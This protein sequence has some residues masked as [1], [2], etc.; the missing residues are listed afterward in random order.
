MDRQSAG[1]AGFAALGAGRAWASRA[2]F[3]LRNEPRRIEVIVGELEIDVGD[4]ACDR[5]RRCSACCG[6]RLGLGKVAFSGVGER[7]RT[8]RGGATCFGETAP[9][10]VGRRPLPRRIS[11]PDTAPAPSDSRGSRPGRLPS[12]L[13]RRSPPPPRRIG[14]PASARGFRRRP[15][16]RRSPSR[17]VQ[18]VCHLPG[19][20]QP[21]TK[22]TTEREIWPETSD[23]SWFQKTNV[24]AHPRYKYNGQP[25]EAF[26][27]AAENSGGVQGAVR[28]GQ[29]SIRHWPG[30]TPR[31]ASAVAVDP[32]PGGYFF[33]RLEADP[34]AS[35]AS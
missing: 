3:R 9:R 19:Q 33:R 15:G 29:G 12:W 11:C 16:G 25:P 30:D 27:A 32:H 6:N 14:R 1:L 5:P 2:V 7:R 4:A 26:P 8:E 31:P 21:T 35:L 20:G 18:P 10:P 17:P 24:G 28:T 34:Q 23:A 22:S 13:P